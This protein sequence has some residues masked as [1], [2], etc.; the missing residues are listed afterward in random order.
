[1]SQFD[2][3]LPFHN[4]RSQC[5]LF[6][7]TILNFFRLNL[8]FHHFVFRLKLATKYNLNRCP[9]KEIQLRQCHADHCELSKPTVFQAQ[10]SFSIPACIRR[11]FRPDFNIPS[12][13]TLMEYYDFSFSF[14]FAVTFRLIT[15]W[16]NSYNLYSRVDFR[17]ITCNYST[18]FTQNNIYLFCVHRTTQ[19]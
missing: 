12:V 15:P 11:R 2:K 7:S 10:Q 5:H 13:T 17:Q 16:S 19:N 8:H 14:F 6:S 18:C 4:S 1:M 3:C 9:V